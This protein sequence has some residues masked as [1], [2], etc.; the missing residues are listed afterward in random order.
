METDGTV[1]DGVGGTIPTDGG[2]EAVDADG[3]AEKGEV[4]F[5]ARLG[6]RSVA[7]LRRGM[8]GKVEGGEGDG[9]DGTASLN[10]FDGLKDHRCRGVW[11]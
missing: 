6:D 7:H 8:V 4:D 2:H 5:L 10:S 9:E 1:G 11:C 3:E